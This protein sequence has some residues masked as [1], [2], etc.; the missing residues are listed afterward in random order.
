MFSGGRKRVHW[1]RTGYKPVQSY[2]KMSSGVS[3]IDFENESPL[4]SRQ[5]YFNLKVTME[6]KENKNLFLMCSR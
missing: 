6:K 5:S 3:F 1:E 4:Q 2:N